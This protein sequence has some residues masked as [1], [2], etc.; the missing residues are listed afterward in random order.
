MMNAVAQFFD[1]ARAEAIV[2]MRPV[3]VFVV[4][5]TSLLFPKSCCT[6]S[7]SVSGVNPRSSIACVYN[8]GF[9]EEPTW[10]FV[11]RLAWSYL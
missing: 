11:F 10:R 4:A 1:Q 9:I 7:T 8:N 6:S 3:H 5:G 2:I